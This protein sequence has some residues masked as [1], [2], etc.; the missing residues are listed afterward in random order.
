MLMME[1]FFPEDGYLLAETCKAA[2]S[3]LLCV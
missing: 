2:V 1:R 3:N